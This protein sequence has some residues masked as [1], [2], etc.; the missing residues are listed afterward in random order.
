[1]DCAKTAQ[2]TKA[3]NRPLEKGGF[4]ALSFDLHLR[5]LVVLRARLT[6]TVACGAVNGAKLGVSGSGAPV[7]TS[8]VHH[9]IF[10]DA[11][12]PILAQRCV[13]IYLRGARASLCRA[14]SGVLL[15]VPFRFLRLAS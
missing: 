2:L 4:P 12:Q 8:C 6:A 9:N 1:M 14:R 13:P 3:G 5:C 15:L 11:A 7:R 10:K